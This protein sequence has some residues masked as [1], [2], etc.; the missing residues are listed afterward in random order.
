MMLVSSAKCNVDEF[1]IAWCISLMY[2]KNNRGPSTDPCGTP[3]LMLIVVDLTPLIVTNW[4][5]LYKYD[6]KQSFAKPLISQ[7]S[8]F[9]SNILCS[10]VSNAFCR[11][12]QRFCSRV[13][14]GMSAFF[15]WQPGQ[16]YLFMTWCTIDWNLSAWVSE[17]VS[18]WV[19]HQC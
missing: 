7:C 2:N 11:Y 15:V 3:F 4:L 12:M 9:F 6:W 14:L 10:T 13:K 8:S 1:L 5:L 18:E 16:R 17:W 19:F